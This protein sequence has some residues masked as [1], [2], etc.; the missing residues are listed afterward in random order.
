MFG[1]FQKRKKAYIH[2]RLD[3]GDDLLSHEQTTQK[4]PHKPDSSLEGL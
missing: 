2:S 1:H 3:P 4:P